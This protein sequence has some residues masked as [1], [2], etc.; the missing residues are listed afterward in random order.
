MTKALATITVTVFLLALFGALNADRNGTDSGSHPKNGT[1]NATSSTSTELQTSSHT[2]ITGQLIGAALNLYHTDHLSLYHN[3]LEQMSDTGFNAVQIVTPMFQ[4]D[5]ASAAVQ[6]RRGKGLGPSKADI[7]SL[8]THAKELGMSTMLMPQINFTKPRG[9]EWRGKL[10]PQHWDPWWAS[11]R[12]AIGEFLEIAEANDVDVFVVGC[13]LL[14]THKP[15]HEARWRDL[16]A[17]S[18]QSFSGRLTYS[19]TW[20]TYP[21][22]GFWD[23]LDAVG[24]SGY[25]DI[26]TLAEDP[27]Q[28]TDD[29]LASRW[30]EIKQRLLAFAQSQDKP[31]LLTEVG[32]PSLPWALTKPWN[33][34]NKDKLP[35]DPEA[36]ARGYAAFISAWHDSIQPNK[37][38]TDSMNYWSGPHPAG[39][40]FHKWDPYH[41]GGP[42]DYGYGVAGKP[43]YRHLIDW[44]NGPVEPAS[45]Q[46][47][48]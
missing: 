15:E 37:Q 48:P 22:V 25:W 40:F 33:Y 12:A 29:E 23:D 39:V 44:L 36:Q 9:N 42:E 18:R 8:L 6:L 13:E 34:I 2:P 16:I 26:T 4:V 11:Y 10:Q 45:Q 17:V 41:R 30:L 19:T 20:D 1:L 27:G 24:V 32:Y 14:T 3:A 7:V 31:V 5:G 47:N 38:E 28:P 21:K 46:L 43:A 35:P